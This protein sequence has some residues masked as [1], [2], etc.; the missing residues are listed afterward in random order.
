MHARY[1]EYC[2]PRET[3]NG[4]SC[5]LQQ[6]TKRLLRQR[7]VT[8]T[9]QLV[10]AML[11]ARNV[12]GEGAG[13]PQRILTA[14]RYTL[15]QNTENL[16]FWRP[17][18]NFTQV[19]YTRPLQLTT[20]YSLLQQ[21]HIKKS[22]RIHSIFNDESTG[23]FICLRRHIYMSHVNKVQLIHVKMICVAVIRVTRVQH[24]TIIPWASSYS[25]S[26]R[27]LRE[28]WFIIQSLLSPV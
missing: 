17:I 13:L 10:W 18:H 12:L 4:Q 5:E 15:V 21:T 1:E 3:A 26:L 16:S 2:N 27:S 24:D 28:A 7:T 6:L 20:A 23:S 9:Y 11:D 25:E 14:K 8:V 22:K 19:S